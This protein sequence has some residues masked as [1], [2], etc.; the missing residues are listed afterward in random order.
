M[1]PQTLFFNSCGLQ[2]EAGLFFPQSPEIKATIILAQGFGALWQFGTNNAINNYV[3]QG[4]AVLAF[5]YRGFGLSEGKPRQ[6]INPHQQIEDWHNAIDYC[7]SIPELTN[8]KIVLWGS[9][10][11]GGHVLTVTA[12]NPKV[13]AVLAQVPHCSS[14][15]AFKHVGLK[16]SASGMFHA[17]ID[18]LH[19]AFGKIHHI[20]I[21]DKPNKPAG[22]N[23]PGWADSY[24][25]MID[26]KMPWENKLPARSLLTAG[27]YNP[28]DTADKISCPVFIAYGEHDQGILVTDV[29]ATIDKIQQC[30]SWRF[31]GDHFEAYDGGSVNR[32]VIDRQLSFLNANIEL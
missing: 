9:S 8:K 15:S 26:N 12:N 21:V 2:C 13:S 23:Y 22:L 17:F 16:K 5:N 30:E 7:L 20:A 4:Y 10:F 31:A 3:D 32:E 11:S 27:N 14:R 24:L 1:N 6:I 28:I 29:E 19:S 18:K 25:S